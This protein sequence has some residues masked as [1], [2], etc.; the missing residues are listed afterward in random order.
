MTKSNSSATLSTSNLYEHPWYNQLKLLDSTMTCESPLQPKLKSET[1]GRTCTKQCK[2]C[3]QIKPIS[4]FTK[5]DGAHRSTRNRCKSCTKLHSNIRKTLRKENP[6]PGPGPCP[7][8]SEHTEQ[9]V[10]DHN[11]NTC[12]FRGYLCKA[13]NAGIGLLADDS[14]RVERALIYLQTHGHQI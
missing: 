8:C 3:L 2:T 4:E 10:L 6:E 11:H 14:T 9:W 12:S 5:A 7:I 1:P 13:C